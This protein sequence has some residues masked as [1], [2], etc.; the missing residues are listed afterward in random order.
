[1]VRWP[2][3]HR[4]LGQWM[5]RIQTMEHDFV[6]CYVPLLVRREAVYGVGQLPK[7]EE[8]LFKTTDGRYLISTAEVS[9]TN[10]VRESVVDAD[11]LPLRLTALTPCFPLPK[12]AAPGAT[13][14]G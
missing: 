13:P 8:D 6:E 5:L 1:M 3:L 12:R 10:T 2:K 4:A 14:R 11:T 9:L 7:F